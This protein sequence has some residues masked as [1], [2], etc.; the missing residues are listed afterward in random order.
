[1]AISIIELIS[2]IWLNKCIGRIPAVFSFILSF[3]WDI[4]IPHDYA[5]ISTNTGIAFCFTIHDVD[6]KNVNGVVIISLPSLNPSISDDIIKASVPDATPIAC[7]APVN[8]FISSLKLLTSIPK[9]KEPLSI[10]LCIALSNYCF[11]LYI[12]FATHKN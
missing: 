10:I 9:I 11:F 6:A 5:S 3:S 4:S 8:S 1:M 7:F 12:L 2:H